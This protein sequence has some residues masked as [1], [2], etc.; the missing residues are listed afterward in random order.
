MELRR[1]NYDFSETNKRLQK[2]L[3]AAKL[4]IKKLEDKLRSCEEARRTHDEAA[5]L[6]NQLQNDI[7]NVTQSYNH[8]HGLLLESEKMASVY[9]SEVEA[10]SKSRLAAESELKCS[11]KETADLL[12]QVDE[13]NAALNALK[14]DSEGHTSK[15][16][17]FNE[18]MSAKKQKYIKAK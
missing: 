9:K 5:K 2:E 3:D 6:I 7:S 1:V 11:R 10:H 16:D 14:A 13:L 8:Q 12:T 4:T 15:I 17:A 18:R